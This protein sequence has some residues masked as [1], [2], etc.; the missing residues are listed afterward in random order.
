MSKE[1]KDKIVRE[2]VLITREHGSVKAHEKITDLF[3][4]NARKKN[5]INEME[6]LMTEIRRHLK[7]QN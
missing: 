3:V 2:L 6:T 7:Y 5:R 4:D 1:F